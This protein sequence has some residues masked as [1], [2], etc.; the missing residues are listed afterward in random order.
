M[1]ISWC[2]ED[3]DRPALS[4]SGTIFGWSADFGVRSEGADDVIAL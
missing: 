1:D 2:V 3:R 4:M